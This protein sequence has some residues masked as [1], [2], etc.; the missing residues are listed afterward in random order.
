MPAE[1]RPVFAVEYLDEASRS[2]VIGSN[3]S[4]EEAV[5][6]ARDEARQRRLGACLVPGLPI[7]EMSSSSLRAHLSPEMLF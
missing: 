3:L 5:E 4:L 7:Q 6:L 1:R 2:Q